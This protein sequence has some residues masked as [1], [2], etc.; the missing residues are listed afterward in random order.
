VT[1]DFEIPAPGRN[2]DF[3]YNFG[4]GAL[5]LTVEEYAI[6]G[7]KSGTQG[8]SDGNLHIGNLDWNTVTVS[9]TITVPDGLCEYVFEDGSAPGQVGSLVVRTQCLETHSRAIANE[10]PDAP[11]AGSHPFTV[12]LER[13]QVAGRV[14]LDPILIRD[15]EPG[16]EPSEESY[17]YGQTPGLK[18]AD[19]NTFEV[20]ADEADSTGG[21]FLPIELRSFGD[22]RSDEIFELDQSTPDEPALYINSDVKLIDRSMQSKAPHGPKR[23][24]KE[25]LK[26]LIAEPVWTELILWTASDVSDGE[27]QHP[28]QES[29]LEILAETVYDADAEGVALD[30]EERIDDTVRIPHLLEEVRKAAQQIV[31]ARS[32]L[33]SLLEEIY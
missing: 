27:P 19:G 5:E 20:S 12:E 10:V 26:N 31:A 21:S 15:P 22:E 23:W 17:R 25:T 8:L 32:D 29:V 16:F 2:D 14:T 4:F 18:L 28:W 9:G 7:G 3:W 1:A 33:E 13:E 30:L 6:D 11:T 24:T